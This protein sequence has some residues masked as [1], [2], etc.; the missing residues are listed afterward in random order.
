MIKRFK[1]KEVIKYYLIK[2]IWDTRN[3]FGRAYFDIRLKRDGL[4]HIIASD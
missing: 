2:A 1:A 3:R 4:E